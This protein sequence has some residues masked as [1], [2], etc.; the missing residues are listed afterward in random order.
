ML[1]GA[2]ENKQDIIYTLKGGTHP[3]TTARQPDKH[4]REG[5]WGGQETCEAQRSPGSGA[6]FVATLQSF[7][8]HK[9]THFFLGVFFPFSPSP[10]TT[11]RLY[12]L[13]L[14]QKLSINHSFLRKVWVLSDVLRLHT[15][16]MPPTITQCVFSDV[17]FN[18][19]P[20]REGRKS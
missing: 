15:R 18:P 16:K 2:G 8:A 19:F 14:L 17:H 9:H 13:R 7:Q 1:R 11:H 12:T 20:L 3:D 6:N 10:V 4:R 5:T